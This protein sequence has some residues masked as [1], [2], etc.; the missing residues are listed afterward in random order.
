MNKNT[1]TPKQIFTDWCKNELFTDDLI[2]E[3]RLLQKAL[4]YYLIE[5]YKDLNLETLLQEPKSPADIAQSLGFVDSADRTIDAMLERLHA[6]FDFLQK[7]NTGAA[8]TF[9]H[10]AAVPN[11]ET[12]V[13]TIRSE[14][15][16]LGDDY[17]SALEF[18]DFGYK[19]FEF[20]LR[21]EPD[22]MDA[23][24]SG[25]E[26]EWQ[27]L[28][29]R[30]TNVDPLQ[31]VHGIM[32]AAAIDALIDSGDILEIGGGTGNGIRNLF[33]RLTAKEEMSR[34]Q[35][36]VFTD[37]SVKFIISTKKEISRDY[38]DTLTEWRFVDLNNP[39]SEQKLPDDSVDLIYAVNAAHV[40]KDIV[41]FLQSCRDT[42]RPNG[43]VLFAERIRLSPRDMAPRELAL[44]LS[45]Y[46]RTAAIRNDDY[47]PTHCYLSPDNWLRVFELAGFEQAEIWPDLAQ[48]N[49]TFPDQY[50]AVVT[51][52][53]K[54]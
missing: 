43:R 38:P 10:V 41:A 33:V 28:W 22:F 50:A 54:S 2:H 5:L 11:A 13:D 48:L 45:I 37:I 40:A 39:I 34:V 17:L 32:G 8:V 46:H 27:E 7:E 25:R 18:L 31:D 47:R 14:L 23:I 16:T 15:K 52:V 3:A 4:D 53:A 29:F 35:R 1:A 19:H 12:H 26:S 6:N 20:A 49:D 30:A 21:D 9:Q 44:N 24:L 42:L 36:Y 51:A